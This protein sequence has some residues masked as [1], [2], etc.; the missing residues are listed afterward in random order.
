MG[1]AG[2]ALAAGMNVTGAHDAMRKRKRTFVLVHGGLHGGW[3]WKKVVP[4]LR[5]AGHDALTPSLS[6]MGERVHL[7]D[8]TIDLSTQ[9]RDV[10]NVLAYE[11][12]REVV[13]VGH[14]YG[15]MVIAGAHAAAHERIAHLVYLDAFL[16]DDGK[17]LSDYAPVP[18]TRE[19]GWRVPPI[20]GPELFG[21]T[22]PDDIAWMTARFGDQPLATFTE[23]VQARQQHPT[24]PHASFIQCT[25][26]P[27]FAEAAERARQRNY[28][29]Y[30]LFTAGHDA[31]VTKPRALAKLL[32]DIASR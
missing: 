28:G 12:L 6:G 22:D 8:S 20:G 26:T 10:V 31:M 2:A 16:P 9:V 30:E 21:V 24:R 23:Q 29:Y 3:C 4:L 25:E 27:W 13:L 7:L 19:D 14:S 11:D 18:P 5:A 15:G 1:M 17:A 32:L